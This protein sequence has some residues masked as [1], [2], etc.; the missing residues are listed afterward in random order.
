MK[1]I[2]SIFSLTLATVMLMFSTVETHH[3]HFHQICFGGW[4][5]S[6]EGEEDEHHSSSPDEGNDNCPLE[7]LQFFTINQGGLHHISTPQ[8]LNLLSSAVISDPS[9]IAA[10]VSTISYETG[11]DI[12]EYYTSAFHSG[13]SRRGPPSIITL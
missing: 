12:S 13:I 11:S 2:L 4:E 6:C 9:H 8:I 7:Q 3:H 5:L 1:R 10:P